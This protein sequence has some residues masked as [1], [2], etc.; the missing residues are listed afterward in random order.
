MIGKPE[1]IVIDVK[2][3]IGR[4]FDDSA[5]NAF[6]TVTGALR[7]IQDPDAVILTRGFNRDVPARFGRAVER[8]HDLKRSFG[9]RLDRGERKGER[10]CPVQS[11]KYNGRE[12]PPHGCAT[13]RLASAPVAWSSLRSLEPGRRILR[14]PSRERIVLFVLRAR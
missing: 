9:L 2:D 1:I 14:M 13:P 5:M 11:G 3:A 12:W 6:G 7:Q 10:A 8:N 4:R